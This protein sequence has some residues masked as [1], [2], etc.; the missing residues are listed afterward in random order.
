MFIQNKGGYIEENNEL[1][2]FMSLFIV[3]SMEESK[4]LPDEDKWKTRK[5]YK[6]KLNKEE[7]CCKAEAS[8]CAPEESILLAEE[9]RN[10]KENI[11]NASAIKNYCVVKQKQVL[12]HLRNQFYSLLR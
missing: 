10:N 6:F 5:P 7:L 3:S 4:L 9:D 1:L 11:L 2:R 12:V 8:A